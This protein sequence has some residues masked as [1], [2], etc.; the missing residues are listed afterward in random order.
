M[1]HIVGSAEGH[2]GVV[3]IKAGRTGVCQM[4]YVVVAAGFRYVYKLHD[5][6]VDIG[7]RAFHSVPHPCLG[8]EVANF[9]EVNV[10]KEFVE[11]VAI[12]N[13]FL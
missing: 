7:I 9:I 13:A 8:C 2:I 11:L 4:F 1:V 12:R 6:A 10:F 5:V 3:A